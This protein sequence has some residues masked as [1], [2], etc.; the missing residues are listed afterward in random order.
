MEVDTALAGPLREKFPGLDVLNADFLSLDLEAAAWPGRVGFI[1]NL[2][3]ECSTAIL[4]KVLCFGR[5][6][7]AVFMFQKEVALRITA[8]VGSA[9]YGY[10]TLITAARAKAS[11][12]TDV[13]AGSFRPVPR[14][15]SSVLVFSPAP[16][17]TDQAREGAYR[18]LLKKAFAHRRKTL[19]NS[20]ALCGV[21]KAAAAAAVERAGF[22]PTVRAQ[23]LTIEG[24]AALASALEGK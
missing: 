18:S 10:L 5:L 12:L 22:L 14:V 4:D 21:D 1:S 17:F 20:L 16:Y 19:V 8:P 24:F 9:E 2:P 11:L 13:K 15:N 6:A 23:E 7:Q 3:Y